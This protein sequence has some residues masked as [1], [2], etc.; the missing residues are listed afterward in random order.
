MDFYPN[1]S[2]IRG[3][4]VRRAVVLGAVYTSSG[5]WGH[6]L[7]PPAVA[8]SASTVAD[9]KTE[10]LT[11]TRNTAGTETLRADSSVPIPHD[12]NLHVKTP[13]ADLL[14]D[15]HL[16]L[17]PTGK[18]TEDG[19]WRTISAVAQSAIKQQQIVET[20]LAKRRRPH[21]MSDHPDAYAPSNGRNLEAGRLPPYK[22]AEEMFVGGV[23]MAISGALKVHNVRS[24]PGFFFV[25]I[26]AVVGLMCA[27]LGSIY[28]VTSYRK[29]KQWIKAQG[30]LLNH[31][32][33]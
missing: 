25:F 31:R 2:G 30:S 26:F 5:L 4:S 27:L 23:L 8:A 11:V 18:R 10:V 20:D 16:H 1:M 9:E 21:P 6:P 15:A 12:A 32:K 3:L 28:Q 7:V 33:D 17:M 13:G 22:G 29:R 24:P 19:K 14:P